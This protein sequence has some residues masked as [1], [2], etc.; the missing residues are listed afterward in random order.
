MVIRSPSKTFVLGGDAA[1]HSVLR[2]LLMERGGQLR[3]LVDP[4]DVTA[5]L[6]SCGSCLL[7]VVL[8]GP[9]DDLLALLA[10]QDHVK[11]RYTLLVLARNLNNHLRRQAFALGAVD[12]IAF[13]LGPSQLQTRLY[14]ALAQVDGIIDMPPRGETLCAGDLTLRTAMCVMS[15]GKG[16][17]CVLTR[18]EAAIL[19]VLMRQ[20]GRVVDRNALLDVVWGENY[21]GTDN[22]LERSIGRLRTKLAAAHDTYGVLHTQRGQGYLFDA[23]RLPRDTIEAQGARS[24][25]I[26]LVDD[27]SV[28]S[29]A[30]AS[31]SIAAEALR[32]AGYAMTTIGSDDVCAAAGRVRPAVILLFRWKGPGQMAALYERLCGDLRTALTPVIVLVDDGDHLARA[33]SAHVDD[34]ILLPCCKEEVVWRVQ[35]VI[36]QR[37]VPIST[38]AST[39]A[40]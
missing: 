21:E 31:A 18:R 8:T 40:I 9:Q 14:A 32:A 15:D 29:D 24:P 19:M 13:P 28:H 16:W 2:F 4:A 10:A 17:S 37:P 11:S 36:G 34:F 22:A 12:V 6:Q 33:A 35:R 39:M 27:T 7:V 26:L 3:V 38:L 25:H 20:P 23:R 30:V 1:T 5:S